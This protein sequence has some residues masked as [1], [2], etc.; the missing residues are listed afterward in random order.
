MGNDDIHGGKF[1]PLE[2]AS[3]ATADFDKYFEDD[4]SKSKKTKK[5]KRWLVIL[6]VVIIL[7]AAGGGGYYFWRKHHHV[8]VP[9][10]TSQAK[11]APLIATQTQQYN[12][13]NFN[14]SF[15]Y[16]TNW[17]VADTT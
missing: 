12:S 9:V 7:V 2:E 14:L 6:V 16:P 1:A 17:T 15:N 8:T 3:K 11:P 13:T 10:T 4:S 5:S